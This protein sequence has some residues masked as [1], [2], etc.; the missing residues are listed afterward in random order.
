M[1]KVLLTTIITA[2]LFHSTNAHGHA[3]LI[4]QNAVQEPGKLQTADLVEAARLRAL[5][6]QLYKE[7]KYKDALPLAQQALRLKENVPGVNAQ[8]LHVA[9]SDLGEIYLALKRYGDAESQF[10]RLIKFY[11]QSDLQDRHLPALLDWVAL[12]RHVRGRPDQAEE[13]YQ[14]ALQIREKLYGPKHATV[15]QSIFNLAEFYQL[16]GSY[17]KAEPLYQRLVVLREEASGASNKVQLTETLDRYAC[18]LRKTNRRAEAEKLEE[19]AY[20][21]APKSFHVPDAQ[22]DGADGG[23]VLNGMA[24][25]LPK[26]TYPEEARRA[27]ASGLVTVKVVIDETGKVMRA[28]GLSGHAL[29]IRESEIAAY[30]ARFTPTM[31]SGM[32]V[33]VTGIITYNYLVR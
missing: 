13:L 7:G 19:R 15:A 29:L 23:N 10:Q 18:L 9:I 8:Q 6:L 24:I 3:S 11:E 32:P 21:P 17:K 26:P 14:R 25:V 1:K 31:L 33:K 12:I 2:S 4:L 27:R 30:R 5:L 16:T 22:N 20:G 28:C